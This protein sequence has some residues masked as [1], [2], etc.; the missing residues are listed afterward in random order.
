M[1][2]MVGLER[3]Q[4]LCMIAVIL[5]ILFFTSIVKMAHSAEATDLKTGEI[6]LGLK[7]L[8]IIDYS[9]GPAEEFE[10]NVTALNVTGL[11]GFQLR[12]TYDPSLIECKL[13]QEGDL[14]GTDRDTTILNFTGDIYASS[15]LTSPEAVANGN[16][17]LVRLKFHVIGRGETS[18]HLHDVNLYD[19]NDV[20]L[21]Y[22]SYDGYFNNK[23]LIDI[24][25]PLTLF[26]VTLASVFLNQKTEGKL[27]TTLED[28]EFRVRDTVML[29]ALMV[30]M[31][32]TIVFL[33]GLIA[34][35][36]ILYLFSFSTLLFIFTYLY[37]K[38]WYVATLPPAVFVVLYLLLRDTSIWGDYLL[39]I[40]GV[41]F[42][43][44]ITL[45]V[46]SLFSWK[47]TL[48]FAGLLTIM[49]I[50]LVLVTGTMIQAVNTAFFGLSL[51]V[52]VGVPIVPLVVRPVLGPWPIYLGLGDFFFAGLLAIQTFKRFG[53]RIAVISVIGMATSFFAWEIFELTFWKAGFPGTVMI[54]CGWLPVAIGKLLKDRFSKA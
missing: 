3:S 16:G 19:P 15:N 9:L 22:M 13:V 40:Y 20:Q 37:S 21:S 17:T 38:R 49:D 51:P 24:A 10:V 28:K 26:A 50:I 32:S 53:K 42:A 7:P 5:L 1:T 44:L 12:L 52:V 34:P 31:I 54:I 4:V 25:M 46:A 48:I 2:N 47:P 35:L 30:A 39:S 45:Y 27:K 8:A 29:V 11:H 23:F 43:I 41:V 33:R 6:T 36:M 18:L 14:L